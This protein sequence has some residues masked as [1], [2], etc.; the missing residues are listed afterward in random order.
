MI[1]MKKEALNM[2]YLK[3]ISPVAL[4]LRYKNILLLKALITTAADNT[5]C[6]IFLNF[7]NKNK[8]KIRYD[9]S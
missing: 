8:R 9:I 3:H 1:E 6:D 4:L 2:A 5:F 7:R